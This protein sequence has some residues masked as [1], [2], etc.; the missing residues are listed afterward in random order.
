MEEGIYVIPIEGSNLLFK[1]ARVREIIDSINCI[2]ECNLGIIKVLQLKLQPID[3]FLVRKEEFNI[4][5]LYYQPIRKQGFNNV[6]AKV[7]KILKAMD[8]S[9]YS[10]GSAEK[11]IYTHDQIKYTRARNNSITQSLDQIV[12]LDGFLLD[13]I[14]SNNGKC[15]IEKELINNKVVI[16][17]E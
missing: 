6:P 12:E 4:G 8:A 11:V 9:L 13:S 16:I 7:G 10:L 17:N 3:L 5:D 14:F 15:F 2:I 1:G